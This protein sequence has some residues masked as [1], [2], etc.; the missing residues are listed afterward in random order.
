LPVRVDTLSAEQAV[1]PKFI[2]LYPNPAQSQ[3]FV[4]ASTPTTIQIINS[5]GQ[6]LLTQKVSEG[7]STISTTTLPSG[8]YSFL[9]E[10]YKATSL[11]IKK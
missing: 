9:A 8:I 11:V 6:I 10:G 3:F 5:L 4:N 7:S 1:P 2:N